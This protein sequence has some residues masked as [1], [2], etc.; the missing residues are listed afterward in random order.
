MANTRTSWYVDFY[1][2]WNLDR[3]IDFSLYVLFCIFVIFLS[4][5]LFSGWYKKTCITKLVRDNLT[6]QLQP[7]V[8]VRKLTVS[9]SVFEEVYNK[10]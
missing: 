7:M 9:D 4:T 2:R 1:S 3:I 8:S 5:N 6:E 10:G